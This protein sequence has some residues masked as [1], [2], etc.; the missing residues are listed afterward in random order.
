MQNLFKGNVIYFYYAFIVFL[1]ASS[2]VLVFV[3]YGNEVLF[4]NKFANT[5]LDKTAILLTQLG[6]G[7]VMG[8][9]ALIF[10]FIRYYYA[11]ATVISL[12][13]TGFFTGVFKKLI[14]NGMPRPTGY[15]NKTDFYHLIPNFNYHE[16]N[17]FPSGHAMTAIAVFLLL[18]VAFNGKRWSV[19]LA[20]F[21]ITVALT[22]IY[23][24]QHFLFD[25][26]VGSILGVL[27]S[28]LGLY[29]AGLIL[30]KD[31]NMMGRSL[32]DESF[33]KRNKS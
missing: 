13:F 17:T 23:L 15:F 8:F 18:A 9:L 5:M 32:L 31:K 7:L 25:V 10:I 33:F 30:K 20:V 11:I 3:P 6:L 12:F 22:R 1:L 28:L 2:L 16:L 26:F 27:C 14:F 29:F 24:L 4:T 21:G 19:F